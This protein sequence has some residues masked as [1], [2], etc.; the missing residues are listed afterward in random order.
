MTDLPLKR[1]ATKS[2]IP[3]SPDGLPYNVIQPSD[4]LILLL[5]YDGRE[6]ATHFLHFSH[7]I[8]LIVPV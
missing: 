1:N 3:K 2:S 5:F 4:Q 7:L 6:L 8:Q